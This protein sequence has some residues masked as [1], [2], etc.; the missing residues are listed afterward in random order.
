MRRLL[1]V[2][3]LVGLVALVYGRVAGHEFL[4]W[5][6]DDYVFQN[7]MVLAGLTWDGVVRAFVESH[8]SNWHPLTWV[9]HMIDVELFELRPGGHHLMSVLFHAVNSVLLFLLLDTTTR[10]RGASTVAAALFAVHPIHVES[11]A[12][13][14][15]R[16]DVLSLCFALLTALAYVR[17]ARRPSKARLAAVAGL[18]ALGLMAKQMLVTLPLLLLLL[19][20]WPLRRIRS[21][22]GGGEKSPFPPLPVAALLLEK[23]P[24]V[25]VSIVA[26][27]VAFG[28]Q[29]AGG[30]VQSVAGRG[31]AARIGNAATSYVA[32]LQKSVW[33][34]D[35]SFYYLFRGASFGIVLLAALFLVAVTIVALR[36]ARRAPYLPVGWLWFLGALVPVIGLVQV[37]DQSMANRYAY[38]PFIG[39]YFVAVFGGRDL[40]R[41]VGSS[42]RTTSAL[43]VALVLVL[44]SVAWWQVGFWK[45]SHTVFGRAIEIDPDHVLAH[46]NLGS[47]L[48][49]DGDLEQAEHHYREADRALPGQPD[50][51]LALAGTLEKRGRVDEA[52]TLY[53]NVRRLIPGDARPLVGLGH[54]ASVSGDHERAL[55]LFE[56]AR[57]HHPNLAI[58]HFNIGR[59]LELKGDFD[60]ATT[61]YARALEIDPL[62]PAWHNALGLVHARRGRNDLAA[63]YFEEACRLFPGFSSAHNNLGQVH[64]LAGRLSEAIVEF[65]R[66]V[67]IDPNNTTARANLAAALAAR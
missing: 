38:L 32:Y 65:E 1:V 33:P 6:D 58:V 55:Q 8:A 35:L 9:S 64:R 27:I 17:H 63:N 18:L 13:I 56:E 39:L 29:A 60:A 61:A 34:I 19:D 14:A 37:G 50:T 62:R 12:W 49:L 24:L 11:V 51:L 15:E 53:E 3:G 5:D 28:A 21:T 20:F 45:S 41:R 36:C 40:L 30:A 67:Q 46:H 2:V 25:L 57:S 47:V 22:H 54:L 10:A 66:A 42:P 23:A 26:S 7:P 52:A 43:S 4:R 44:A 31:I 16:K 59:A 48:E